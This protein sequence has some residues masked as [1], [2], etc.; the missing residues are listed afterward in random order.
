[1]MEKFVDEHNWIEFL[2]D[3]KKIRSNTSVCLK[4]DVTQEKLNGII[5]ILEAEKV[6]VDCKSYRDAPLGLR[7]WCGATIDSEDIAI[8]L[9]WLEWAFDE[10][11]V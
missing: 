1:V 7:F 3:D 11:N 2:A 5:K 9:Q 10:V 6:A 8:V 4:L